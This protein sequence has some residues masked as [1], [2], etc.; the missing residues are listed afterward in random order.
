MGA[1]GCG[2]TQIKSCAI[3]WTRVGYLRYNWTCWNISDSSIIP[4][5]YEAL[6]LVIYRCVSN[7]SQKWSVVVG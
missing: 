6:A 7:W 2:R 3:S 4:T 1:G 5:G